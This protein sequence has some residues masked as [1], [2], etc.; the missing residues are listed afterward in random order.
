M[1]WCSKKQA[2]SETA[3]Y[4]SEFVSGRTCVEQVVDLRNSFRCLGVPLNDISYIFGDNE[5]MINIPSFPHAK[6]HKR[7]NILSYQYFRSMVAAGFIAIHHI[8]T[9]CNLADI[10]TKH[11]GNQSVWN[12]LQPVLNWM[13]NTANLYE[14]DDPMRLHNFFTKF[15]DEE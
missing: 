1:T 6:L 15:L 4:G 11:W 3:T 10:L 12:L 7:Y 8:P 5:T 14:D 13:G 9:S 2:T